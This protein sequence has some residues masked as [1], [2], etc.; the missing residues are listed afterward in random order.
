MHL[1]KRHPV[2]DRAVPGSPDV[3]GH[4]GRAFRSRRVRRGSAGAGRRDRPCGASRRR[5]AR[6]RRG[7]GPRSCRR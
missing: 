5:G 6:P 4:S 7:G 1:S 2:A 3:L